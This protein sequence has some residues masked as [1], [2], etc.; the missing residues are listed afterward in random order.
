[1]N[2]MPA[3]GSP[4]RARCAFNHAEFTIGDESSNIITA[5]IQL[6]TAEHQDIAERAHV[7]FY[8]SDDA[9][10]DSVIATGVTSLAA[11]TDG[12]YRALVAAKSGI[13][14]SEA[15][16]DIDLAIEFTG[17]AKT[18]YLVLEMPDGSLLVSDAITFA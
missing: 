7:R 16:G 8:L 5:G 13:L 11:G 15:D 2:G 1:M 12:H 9:N 3:K 4:F 18:V 6:Q 10:G 14:V 17:G